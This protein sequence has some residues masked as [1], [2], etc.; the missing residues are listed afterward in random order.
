M[1][2]R[3]ATE[4]KMFDEIVEKGMVTSAELAETTGADKVLIGGLN[5]PLLLIDML[6]SRYRK[7]VPRADR[8]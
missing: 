4:L 8:F 1:A 3:V 6:T 5:H 7:I 2:V